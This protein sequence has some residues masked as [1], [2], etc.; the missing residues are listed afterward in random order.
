MIPD[1]WTPSAGRN[2]IRLLADSAKV[3]QILPTSRE[4]ESSGLCRVLFH[5]F[6]NLDPDLRKWAHKLAKRRAA[7]GKRDDRTRHRIPSLSK[8]AHGTI[9][10]SSTLYG[11]GAVVCLITKRMRLDVCATQDGL[12]RHWDQGWLGPFRSKTLPTHVG[13]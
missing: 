1:R 6:H 12:R 8:L 5:L 13:F 2:P 7:K 3:L 10:V 4:N 11:N 9:V